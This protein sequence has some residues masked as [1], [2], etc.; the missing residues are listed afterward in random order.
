MDATDKKTAPDGAVLS[1]VV[2]QI[3]LKPAN[4]SG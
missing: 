1:A 2:I 3:R 4:D